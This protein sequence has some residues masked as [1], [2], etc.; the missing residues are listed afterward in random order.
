MRSL[1]KDQELKNLPGITIYPLNVTELES[2]RQAADRIIQDF[3]TINVLVNNAG[4]AV[5]GPLEVASDEAI[6]QQVETNLFGVI[7]VTKAILPQ[8]RKQRD[9]VIIN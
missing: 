4:F 6:R 7:N 5:T 9:G 8:M 2:I 3:G 1:E